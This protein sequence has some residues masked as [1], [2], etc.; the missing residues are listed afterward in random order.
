[1]RV[2]WGR[3]ERERERGSKGRGGEGEGRFYRN[4][5]RPRSNVKVPAHTHTHILHG[6]VRVIIEKFW[7][8]EKGGGG[9]GNLAFTNISFSIPNSFIMQAFETYRLF[10]SRTGQLRLFYIFI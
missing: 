3:N 4:V 9:G 7:S 6:R 2:P 10:I 1:M 5:C 8:S